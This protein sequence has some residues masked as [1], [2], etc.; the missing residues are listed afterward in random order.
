MMGQVGRLLMWIGVALFLFGLVVWVTGRLGPLGRLP[1]DFYIRRGNFALYLPLG[2]S[3]VLSLLLSLIGY[4][5]F[6]R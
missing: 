3:L 5:F 4:L 6:R 2:T 1:G